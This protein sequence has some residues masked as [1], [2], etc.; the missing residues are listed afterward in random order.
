MFEVA[1]KSDVNKFSFNQTWLIKNSHLNSVER[2]PSKPYIK[3]GYPGNRTVVVN[4]TA[5]LACPPVS[6]LEPYL[7]WIKPYDNFTVKD[8]EVG[9]NELPIPPGIEIEVFTTSF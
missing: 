1:N 4:D 6:D 2:Y 9:P 8:G 5:Q 3:E 7:T